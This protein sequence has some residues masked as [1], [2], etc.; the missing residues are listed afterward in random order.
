M[1][2]ID[3]LLMLPFTGFKAVMNTLMKVALDEY[4]DD[5]PLKEELLNLQMRLDTGEI[6][7][8]QYLDGEAEI[9]RALREVQNR[10]LELAGAE[11]ETGQGLSGKVMEGSGAS[12]TV[13]FGN[14]GND[15]DRERR[16]QDQQDEQR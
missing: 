4:T 16:D 9:L 7:E 10:K 13:Q 14:V 1:L 11:P 15:A 2:F 3:D 6:T 8:E 5:A 12:L